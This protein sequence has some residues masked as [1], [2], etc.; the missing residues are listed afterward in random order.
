[1]LDGLGSADELYGGRGADG[2][3]GRFGDDYIAGG[4]G[5]DKLYGNPG[6]DRIEAADGQHDVVNCGSDKYDRASVDE[7]DTVERCEI[8]NGEQAQ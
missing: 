7:E 5:Q 4:R 1:M 3:L 8:V 6:N 2:I